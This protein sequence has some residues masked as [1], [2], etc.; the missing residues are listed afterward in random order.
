MKHVR[1]ESILTNLILVS[2]IDI[3]Q[4]LKLFLFKIEHNNILLR[5]QAQAGFTQQLDLIGS[6]TAITV[7]LS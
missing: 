3:N 6:T 4:S 2:V 5:S 7:A 1:I